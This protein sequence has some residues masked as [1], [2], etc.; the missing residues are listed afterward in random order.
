MPGGGAKKPLSYSSTA[1]LGANT[2]SPGKILL[3]CLRFQKTRLAAISSDMASPYAEIQLSFR[4]VQSAQLISACAPTCAHAHIGYDGSVFLRP[5]SF[6][7]KEF[8][9]VRFFRSG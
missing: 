5:S 4:C 6:G 3:V 8:P 7:P 1:Q 2:R 9:T